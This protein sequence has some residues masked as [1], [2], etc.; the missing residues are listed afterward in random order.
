MPPLDMQTGSGASAHGQPSIGMKASSTAAGSLHSLA[1]A[2]A[3]SPKSTVA[4]EGAGGGNTSA[5]ER[6]RS[7][8]LKL[9]Q[10][11]TRNATNVASNASAAR[12]HGYTSAEDSDDD[13]SPRQAC[14]TVACRCVAWIIRGR[15]VL[16]S[17]C[18]LDRAL[19][20]FLYSNTDRGCWLIFCASSL[21]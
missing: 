17:L 15:V 12:S 2:A 18:C 14:C 16:V 11:R 19:P 6:R 7:R 10:T 4:G 9:R 21:F 5:G 3:A 13:V 20:F 1:E 8:A